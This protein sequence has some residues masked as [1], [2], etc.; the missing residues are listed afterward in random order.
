MKCAVCLLLALLLS[1][2]A[3]RGLSG[4]FCG[5]LPSDAAVVQV[6][7]DA[8]SFLSMSYPPGHTSLYLLP[9]KEA[10]N[11]FARALESGLRARGFTILAQARKDAV[12]VAYTLDALQDES[13]WYLQLRLSDG[14]ALSRAYDAAGMPEAGR[15]QTGVVASPDR[16]EQ[17][18]SKAACVL[19]E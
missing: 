11:A 2:C 13:S 12:S 14:R 3:G 16:A 4:S 6:A 7:Q 18:T 15:S 10:D 5:P 9:A 8:V 1:G 19:S 17:L